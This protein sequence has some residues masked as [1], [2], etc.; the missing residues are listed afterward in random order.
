MYHVYILT[1]KSKTVLYTGFTGNLSERIAQ[2]KA[3]EVKGFTKKYNVN[4]LIYYETFDDIES[5]KQRE[6]A[7]KKW[8]RAWKE[9]LINK[10]NPNWDE[11]L[12][13]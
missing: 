11:V 5:A 7:L 10:S 3:G 1:N 6:K 8:N 12:I 13:I 2:H 4:S 9:N